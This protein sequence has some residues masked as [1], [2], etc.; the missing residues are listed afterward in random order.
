MDTTLVT[1]LDQ[2]SAFEL[3]KVDLEWVALPEDA[4]KESPKQSKED[5]V[6]S[7]RMSKTSDPFRITGLTMSVPK[8][9]LVAICGPVRSVLLE[10]A[11]IPVIAFLKIILFS[12]RKR[13]I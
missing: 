3:D 8:G 2:S 9:I 4:T 10:P 1:D 13:Q 6:A 5:E 11:V 12:D 7:E